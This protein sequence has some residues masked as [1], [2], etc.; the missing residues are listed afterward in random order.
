MDA[1]QTD[2]LHWV[3]AVRHVVSVG[4]P[5]LGAPLEKGVNLMS[6][7]L[8]IAPETR[9][10]GEFLDRRSAGIKD[11]RFG[12]IRDDDWRDADPA[13]LFD[14][15]AG[16]VSFPKHVQQHF[17]AGVVTEEPT[18]PI[19]VLVGDLI[20]RTGSGTGRGRR[21]NIEATNVRV[22]G[23]RRH[24]DLAGDPVVHQQV[25]DWLATSAA[26]C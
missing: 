13:V 25:R 23:K 11:L 18:H 7:G 1:G 19:G 10:I 12:A 16:D 14:G 8:L 26:I 9:P 3:D 4:A 21:R 17:V 5:H 15:I 6:W 22:I 2:R 20:V 24:S